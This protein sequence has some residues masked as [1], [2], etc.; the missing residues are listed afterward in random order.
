M[1]FKDI[2]LRA[3]LWLCLINTCTSNNEAQKYICLTSVVATGGVAV[4]VVMGTIEEDSL[5]ALVVTMP[6][7]LGDV[8]TGCKN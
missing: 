4:V 1:N 3:L 6:S 8:V 5:A 2:P 7:S